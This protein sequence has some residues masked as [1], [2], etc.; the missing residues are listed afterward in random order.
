MVING[1]DSVSRLVIGNW[2]GPG[3][4]DCAIAVNLDLAKYALA[5]HCWDRVIIGFLDGPR[6]SMM[7]FKKWLIEQPVLPRQIWCTYVAGADLEDAL[8]NRGYKHVPPISGFGVAY[9]RA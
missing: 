2:T 4:Q 6:G 7:A 3:D 1:A 8:F 5:T 9:E